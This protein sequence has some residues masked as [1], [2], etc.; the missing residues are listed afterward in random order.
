MSAIPIYKPTD[1]NL[2][3]YSNKWATI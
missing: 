2:Y 1:D 3:F